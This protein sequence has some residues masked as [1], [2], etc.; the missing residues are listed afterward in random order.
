MRERAHLLITNPD[1]LHCSILPVHRQFSRFL[2]NLHYVVV[3]EGHA[4]RCA[5]CCMCWD[6]FLLMFSLSVRRALQGWLPSLLGCT[7]GVFGCHAALVLRRLQRICHREYRRDPCFM[8]ASATIANPQ[9][10]IQ[11][12][13]G[14]TWVIF[15]C[16]NTCTGLIPGTHRHQKGRLNAALS[17]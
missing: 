4:Y 10:H 5:A 12:L 11:Q 9:E 16:H 3:D 2:A 14:E 6:V 15:S 13:L 7:R 17:S 8:V 1:M